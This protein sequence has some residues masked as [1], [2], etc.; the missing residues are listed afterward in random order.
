MGTE[1]GPPLL[2]SE[3]QYQEN[4]IAGILKGMHGVARIL[5]VTP[6]AVASVS[7]DNTAILNQLNK[8][9]DVDHIVQSDAPSYPAYSTYD[10]IVTGSD[11]DTAWTASNLDHAK[12]FEGPI[13]C[14]DETMA[15]QFLMGTAGGDAAS[16]TAMTA[17]SQIESTILG[18]GVKGVTGLAAG[19]NTISSSATF[20][21]IDM[22]DA[23]L[24]ETFFATETTANNTD[25][26]L[27]ALYKRQPDGTRGVLTD[28]ADAEG[29]RYFYGPAYS[30]NSLTT[31]GLAVLRLLTQM[32]IEEEQG[33]AGSDAALLAALQTDVDA[34]LVDT[35]ELQG[36]WANGGRLDLLIDAIPTTAMRGT[37]NAA[38]A[39]AL[40][41]VDN[42]IAVIDGNVDDILADTNSLQT[43][44]ADG[45]R[46]DALIDSIKAE[47]ATIVADT[48]ELQSDD[49]PGLIAT[50][51]A[52][53]DTVKAET[54]LILEDTGTTLV[55]QIN[56]GKGKTQVFDKSITVA[57]NAG[58]TTVATVAASGGGCIIESVI[59]H[60]DAAQTGDLTNAPITGGASG[61][62]TFLTG[63]QTIQDNLD[64]ADEQVAW[65]GAVYL[66]HGKTIVITPAGTG[67]TALNLTVSV[68]YRASVDGGLIS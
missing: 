12:S 50:L 55:A 30:A 60:A 68:T 64:A 65:I 20:N 11:S 26:L 61:A 59:L 47:T 5:F 15:V 23:Q 37:D 7:D 57:A 44:W 32:A 52:V 1:Y 62:V 4:T 45:G 31:L 66:A 18:M 36:D 63:A 43:E 25:V 53:V 8:I 49:V 48:N 46:L 41:T 16:K 58:A 13:I 33:S 28:A 34:V 54:V 56:T 29:S 27:G 9:G 24:T 14:V 39:S 42:E 22:S 35:N 51:D 19:A 67:G 2:L 3:Q 38:T 21:T 6:E 10:L 17:I 40:T